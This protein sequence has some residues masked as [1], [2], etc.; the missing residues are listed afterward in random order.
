MAKRMRMSFMVQIHKRM[1]CIPSAQHTAQ[2]YLENCSL[3]SQCF[4]IQ[5]KDMF[6]LVWNTMFLSSLRA[7]LFLAV[8]FF[9]FIS[10]ERFYALHAM[11]YDKI[12]KNKKSS[13]PKHCHN[14]IMI[15]SLQQTKIVKIIVIIITCF[16]TSNGSK[17]ILKVC[18]MRAKVLQSE[19]M[20]RRKA[21]EFVIPTHFGL[22]FTIVAET[23][24]RRKVFRRW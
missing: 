10:C 20:K 8:A 18:F 5:F 19:I 9:L 23:A 15:V 6:I 12:A 17:F 13:L 14:R 11:R 1:L 2:F 16:S 22:L 21:C 7:L 4:F 3:S 24:F